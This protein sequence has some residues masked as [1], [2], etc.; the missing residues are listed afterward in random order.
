MNEERLFP[1]SSNTVQELYRKSGDHVRGVFADQP[2]RAAEHYRRYVNFVLIHLTRSPSRILDVGCGNGWSTWL[3]RQAGHDALGCDLHGGPL[4]AKKVDPELG[5]TSADAQRLPFADSVFDMVAMHAVLEHVPHPARVLTECLRVLRPGGRLIV[6]GPH[7]LSV[8][9]SLS[10]VLRETW[11][12]LLH[13]GRTMRRGPD[14]P[15]HPFGNTLQE[16]YWYLGH[17][18]FR[19]LRKLWSERP[20]RFLLREPDPRPPF[21][22]DNDACYYCNPMDLIRWAKQISGVLSVRWWAP[23]R[24]CARWLWPVAGGTWVVL[25]KQ[26]DASLRA[27]R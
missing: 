19:T 10:C 8:G 16:V 9:I 4:E 21:D 22:A 20:V 26:K 3:L 18:T 23:D 6:V 11:K 15:K 24:R 13:S 17:H 25:E 7:L 1:M 27:S 12:A 2:N 5:Y 14:T